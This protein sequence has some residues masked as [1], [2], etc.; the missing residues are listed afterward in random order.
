MSRINAAGVRFDKG[1]TIVTTAGHF[2]FDSFAGMSRLD[3]HDIA[4]ALSKLCRYTGWCSDFYSVAEHSVYVEREV[5]RFMRATNYTP[6]RERVVRLGAVYHDATESLTNDMSKPLK[7]R[8]PDYVALEARLERRFGELHGFA[9]LTDQ[10]RHM[11]KRADKA[12]Y[13][14]ERLQIMPHKQE[15]R[16]WVREQKIEPADIRI[17]CLLPR[18]AERLFIDAYEA[19]M[20]ETPC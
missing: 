2:D 10:E 11:I 19:I 1:P 13:A 9:D 4:H 7:A 5:A 3:H 20:R 15:I 6:S 16:D 14:A 8:N 17:A 18:Q 12:L